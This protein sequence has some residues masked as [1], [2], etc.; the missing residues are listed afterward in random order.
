MR[1]GVGLVPEDRKRQGLVLMMSGRANFSM[2]M[3]DRLSRM[4]ILTHSVERN[5]LRRNIFEHLRVKT[6][7][8]DTPV[9]Q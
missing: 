1:S 5:K 2:A 6:P 4:G 8:I 9:R 3:L 7:S